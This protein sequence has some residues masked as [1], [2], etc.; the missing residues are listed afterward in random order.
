MPINGAF[1]KQVNWGFIPTPNFIN[2]IFLESLLRVATNQHHGWVI[3]KPFKNSSANGKGII[4]IR[5]LIP[6]LSSFQK[7]SFGSQIL[8]S[9]NEM[10]MMLMTCLST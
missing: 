7:F 4:T 2:F 1:V 8:L 6:F 9:A 10:I 5:V 3:W